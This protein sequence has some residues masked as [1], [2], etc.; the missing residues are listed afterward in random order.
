MSPRVLRNTYARRK[1]IAGRSHEDVNA[2]LG[3]G[4]HRTVVRLQ[5]TIPVPASVKSPDQSGANAP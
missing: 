1:L 5:E 2:V 3:I 4:T